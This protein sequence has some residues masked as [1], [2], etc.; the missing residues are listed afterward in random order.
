MSPKAKLSSLTG[1]RFFLALWVVIY[2]QT[3]PESYLGAWLP[4]LPATLF[5]WL[6]TGYV[7]VDFFF[8]L[9]GFVLS[10]A[11][12]LETGPSPSQML[13]YAFGR[14]ARIYPVYCFGLLMMLPFV[15][16]YTIKHWSAATLGKQ[17]VLAVLSATLV[18]SWLPHAALSWDFPAWSL[19]D[20][21]FFYSCF[22]FVGLVLWKL[23][24]WRNILLSAM[25]F[26]VAA[27]IPPMAA[28]HLRR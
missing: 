22:F 13:Q 9:S 5:C 4:R 24:G 18:Q 15:G 16:S 21:A 1:I 10:Y 11:H 7:A 20:E 27:L 8:V 28:L 19:S 14:F 23:S 25:A 26:W 2:H 3:W 6:R 17:A 12:S